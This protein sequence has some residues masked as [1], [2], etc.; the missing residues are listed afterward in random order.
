MYLRQR[1]NWMHGGLKRRGVLYIHVLFTGM[2]ITV[3]AVSTM[4]FHRSQAYELALSRDHENAKRNAQAA[5]DIALLKMRRYP[6]WRTLYSNPDWG[7]DLQIGNGFYSI[8]VTDPVDGILQNKSYD[9]VQMRVVGKSG[10]AIYRESV[11]ATV[12]PAS[13]SCLDI[14]MIAN[15]A[16]SIFSSTLST[17]QTIGA[18]GAITSSGSQINSKVEAGG[19][20]SGVYYNQTVTNGVDVRKMP[21]SSN[22]LN[23]YSNVATPI[24]VNSLPLFTRTEIVANSGIESNLT[25]WASTPSPNTCVVN[26]V[27]SKPRA[28]SKCLEVKNRTTVASVAKFTATTGDSGLQRL[29]SG[30]L[31]SLTIPIRVDNNCNIKPICSITSTL[32]GTQD[33]GTSESWVAA[34]KNTSEANDYTLPTITFR[35]TFAGAITQIDIY[36]AFQSSRTDYGM[37]EVTLKDITYPDNTRVFERAALTPTLNPYGSTSSNGVYRIDCGGQ[38]VGFGYGRIVGTVVI[39]NPGSGSGVYGPMD[40]KPQ[41]K[42]MPSLISS[43]DLTVSMSDQSLN[44]PQIDANLN[45]PGAPVPFYQGIADTDKL[46]SYPSAIEGIVY[47]ANDIYLLGTCKANGVVI[48]GDDIIAQNANA[49]ISYDRSIAEDPPPGF[50]VGLID[51]NIAPGS[52]TRTVE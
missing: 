6:N 49:V 18:N 37:D 36:V 44:E 15:D 32:S 46:D 3:I 27:S 38:V 9:P 21:T 50:D 4:R 26:R 17:D 24:S 7:T 23:T 5:I 31:Y 22:V 8:T 34:T 28:G 16:I 51:I 30:H 52:W 20:A 10:G 45:P 41:N 25:G 48:A 40:W 12:A 42:T 11:I 33:F 1:S 39:N 19:T 47:A 29:I 35:P 2:I 43:D 13:G 14:A